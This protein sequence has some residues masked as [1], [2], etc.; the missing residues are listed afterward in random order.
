M[1]AEFAAS[2][3]GSTTVAPAM[4]QPVRIGLLELRNRVVVSPMDM[5]SA[6]D[7]VPGD[8]HLVHLG[9]KAMGGAGLVM[10]EMTCVS[11]EGRITPGCAGL[12]TDGQRDA[13]ARIV[14]FVHAAVR[15]ADRAAA[16]PCRPQ[17]LDEAHVGG[18]G[19]AAGEGNWE[20]IGPSPLPYGPAATY[21]AR[22]PRGHGPGRR[23][24][25]RRGAAWRA[26]RVRPDRAALRARLPAL[27]VPLA[28]RQ[29]AHRR[30]RRVSGEPA[31]LP[32]RGVRRRPRGRWPAASP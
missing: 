31:A 1:D 14:D 10:T 26:G 2:R 27:L 18:H 25:R 9:S 5:Y 7:G 4:F 23:R 15:R 6:V 16:R 22:R 30:V 32:A 29:P 24:I 8:F 17:G 20:L 12:W 11:P 21:R 19:R 13:W 28:D 3:R